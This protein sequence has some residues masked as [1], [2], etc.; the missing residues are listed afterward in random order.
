MPQADSRLGYKHLEDTKAKISDSML[1]NTNLKG[2]KG[3]TNPMFG[4]KGKDHPSFGLLPGNAVSVSI[5]NANDN[6]LI[7]SFPSQAAAARFLNVDSSTVSRHAKSGKVLN[8][9]FIITI[10]SDS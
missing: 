9:L 3:E 10:K 5:Y 1:G 8:N 4:I 6:T 7:Q 2:M